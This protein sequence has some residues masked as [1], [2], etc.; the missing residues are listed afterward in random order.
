M[1]VSLLHFPRKR[2]AE[3][4][5]MLML[6]SAYLVFVRSFAPPSTR[7][8]KAHKVGCDGFYDFIPKHLLL[9]LWYFFV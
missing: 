1:P 9:D 8:F 4:A 3:L 2:A 6:Y 7:P 5:G